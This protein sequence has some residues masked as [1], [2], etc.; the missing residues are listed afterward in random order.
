MRLLSPCDLDREAGT[1][2]LRIADVETLRLH[3]ARAEQAYG[4]VGV[5]AGAAA[6]EG[7]DLPARRQ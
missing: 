1:P 4:V 2:P 3:S 7:D 5:D 6:A